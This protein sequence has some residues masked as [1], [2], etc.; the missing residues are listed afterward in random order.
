MATILAVGT[1]AATSSDFTVAAGASVTVGL[2]VDSGQFPV[3]AKAVLYI[4]SPGADVREANMDND[5][6]T[7]VIGGPCTASVSREQCGTAFGVY[8]EV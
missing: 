6:R 8:T 3:D 5:N 4:N 7:T 1:T 2:Y